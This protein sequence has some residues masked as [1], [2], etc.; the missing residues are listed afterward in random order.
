MDYVFV[1]GRRRE[2]AVLCSLLMSRLREGGLT[3]AVC[4]N[5]LSSAFGSVS[6]DTLK[7]VVQLHSAVENAFLCQQRF[8]EALI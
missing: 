6:H 1:K 3:H 5:D 2:E 8:T 7:E 4:L